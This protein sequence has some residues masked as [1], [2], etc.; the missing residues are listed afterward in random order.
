M[1]GGYASFGTIEGNHFVGGGSGAYGTAIYVDG[2]SEGGFGQTGVIQGNTLGD[3]SGVSTASTWDY[4]IRITGNAR[5]VAVRDNHA[6]VGLNLTVTVGFSYSGITGRLD[7]GLIDDAN[8]YLVAGG[9]LTTAKTLPADYTGLQHDGKYN[10]KALT[11]GGVQVV[12]AQGAAVANAGGGTTVD[13]E[14][15]AAINTLLAR[16]RAHGLIAS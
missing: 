6:V 15:R 1:Q 4:F 14:A 13:T 2:S 12:G 8:S 16:L 5:S 9:A 7:E 11:V 3:G 10:V